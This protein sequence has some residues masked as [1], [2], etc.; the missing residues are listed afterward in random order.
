MQY[1]RCYKNNAYGRNVYGLSQPGRRHENN[2][3]KKGS[4]KRLQYYQPS[5]LH[6]RIVTQNYPAYFQIRDETGLSTSQFH[7]HH[8]ATTQR[9]NE[10]YRSRL[11][12]AQARNVHSGH[13]RTN[14]GIKWKQRSHWSSPCSTLS[15]RRGWTHPTPLVCS[16]WKPCGDG[17]RKGKKNGSSRPSS[18]RV[19]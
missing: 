8:A 13:S 11:H 3:M 7:L 14:C 15:H 16:H 5:K 19:T 1:S 2:G 6:R 18:Q 12:R 17:G 10:G 9:S 4:L